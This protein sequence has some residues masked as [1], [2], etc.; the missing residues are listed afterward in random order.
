MVRIA[1]RGPSHGA[2]TEHSLTCRIRKLKCDESKP[3]CGNCSKSSRV[4]VF[5]ER[6]V[7]RNVEIRSLSGCRKQNG[8]DQVWLDV[9]KDCRS[10]CISTT[11]DT[12]ADVMFT[13]TFILV[14]DP[15]TFDYPASFATSSRETYTTTFSD[16]HLETYLEGNNSQR[17]ILSLP[18]PAAQ[19]DTTSLINSEFLER[20]NII[21]LRLLRH[22]GEGPGQ[23]FIFRDSYRVEQLSHFITGWMF[24]IPTPT[25]PKKFRSWPSR[26]RS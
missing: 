24:S 3:R 16:Q 12:V 11:G 18:T 21:A 4:C 20:E 26:S 19:A 5:K 6:V 22:F 7:F 9:P 25:S 23:W 15:Y 8:D 13:V 2:E 17:Q 1:S 10:D 14:D